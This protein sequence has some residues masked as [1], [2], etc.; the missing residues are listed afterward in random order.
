MGLTEGGPDQR[1]GA[2]TGLRGS[3]GEEGEISTGTE[4][5]DPVWGKSLDPVGPARYSLAVG[6]P[7]YHGNATPTPPSF[8]STT[9]PPS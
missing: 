6:R 1:M 9:F 8:M 7:G 3:E 4:E 2:L 5:A